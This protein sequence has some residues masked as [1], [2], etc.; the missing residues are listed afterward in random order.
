[1]DDGPSLGDLLGVLEASSA[2]AYFDWPSGVIRL[3]C[4]GEELHRLCARSPEEPVG[5]LEPRLQ[6]I[7]RAF[8]H[9]SYHFA[10]IATCGYPYRF[11]CSVY[12]EIGGIF[13]RDFPSLSD[14]SRLVDPASATRIRD[15]LAELDALGPEGLSVRRLMEADAFLFQSENLCPELRV[16]EY[17]ALLDRTC[18]HPD[19][20]YAFDYYTSHVGVTGVKWF[21]LVTHLALCCEHPPSAF[22]DL[23][24]A[25]H[26]LLQHHPD[27][28][29]AAVVD[30]CIYHLREFS[31]TGMLGS[32]IEVSEKTG[33]HH[34]IYSAVLANINAACEATEGEPDGFSIDR[35]FAEPGRYFECLGIETIRPIIL[36]GVNG[37]RCVY[38]PRAARSADASYRA[39]EGEGSEWLWQCLLI[40]A[41]SRI[42]LEASRGVDAMESERRTRD[43]GAAA[44]EWERL[45]RTQGRCDECSCPITSQDSYL[46]LG[47]T[48]MI[49]S[50]RI[51]SG[52]YLVCETCYNSKYWS[53]SGSRP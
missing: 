1:M 28:G 26:V 16:L 45:S 41:V 6:E 43:K 50:R 34:P 10:Q 15:A 36:D 21:H 30:R 24:T 3:R 22:A 31:D 2:A 7:V 38:D 4:S 5:A 12:R 20:R 40:A 51:Q 44:R 32:S 48:V 49:G 27:A 11:A 8:A 23:A 47:P 37:K 19:Y 33:L 46:V 42:V 35:Y 13:L 25:I 17:A 9:E 18:P 14:V 29:P 53:P 52:N 39:V